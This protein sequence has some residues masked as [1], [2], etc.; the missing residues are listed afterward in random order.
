VWFSNT[1]GLLFRK[2]P[3]LELIFKIALLMNESYQ[4]NILILFGDVLSVM[5]L[6]V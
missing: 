2:N 1:G 3:K 4:F 6:S 5:V